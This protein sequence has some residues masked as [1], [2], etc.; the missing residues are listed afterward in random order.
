MMNEYTLTMTLHN[1]NDMKAVSFSGLNALNFTVYS[2]IFI[3]GVPPATG[4]A[5]NAPPRGDASELIGRQPP[6]IALTD[7]GLP[8]PIA[9]CSKTQSC[10]QWATITIVQLMLQL[11]EPLAAHKT[12]NPTYE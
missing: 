10:L 7:I 12:Y 8:G 5:P 6:V 1:Q 3:W 2:K 9:T 11:S 4:A